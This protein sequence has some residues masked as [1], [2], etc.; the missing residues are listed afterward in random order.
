M[1][2]PRTS[3]TYVCR[4]P[5]ANGNR[6]CRALIRAS[7]CLRSHA[8]RKSRPT[9]R[10]LP[11]CFNASAAESSPR[12]SNQYAVNVRLDFA[13][14]F[15][16]R[17]RSGKS[18]SS[19]RDLRCKYSS[20]DCGL[21]LFSI[22]FSSQESVQRSRVNLPF[23]R[24]AFQFRFALRRQAVNLARGRRIFVP[25]ADDK[26]AA[27]PNRATPGKASLRVSA[28]AFSLRRSTSRAMA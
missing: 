14:L 15:V 20:I 24:A 7:G 12:A 11:N 8:R 25:R 16:A 21:G 2:N 13:Q 23:A 10:G 1:H 22:D 28:R 17:L 19:L 3:W 26:T 9:L 27:L 18:R 6:Q 4:Q 5:T